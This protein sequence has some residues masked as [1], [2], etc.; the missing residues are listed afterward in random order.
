MAAYWRDRP[1]HRDSR[2]TTILPLKGEVSPK[3]TE[4]E[5]HATAVAFSSPSVW[6][7]PAT[8][9]VRGRIVSYRSGIN[10]VRP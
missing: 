2:S 9:P 5:D 6:Q 1:R 7:G 8:S 4:G 3:V 10:E